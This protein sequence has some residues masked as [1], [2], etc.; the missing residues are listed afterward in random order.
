M[1]YIRLIR[2]GGIHSCSNASVFLTITNGE[3]KLENFCEKYVLSAMSL[4]STRSL[5]NEITH[6]HQNYTESMEYFRVC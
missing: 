6:L 2:S 4:N 5:E 1:G 3:L